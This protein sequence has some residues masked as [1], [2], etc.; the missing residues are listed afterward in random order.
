VKIHHI[1][2]ATMVIET[3]NMV[4]LVDPML[5]DKG[6][7]PS[8][9]EKRFKSQKNPIVPLPKHT[10]KILE[11]VTHCLITHKHEDHLDQAGIDFLK[12]QNIPVFCSINDEKRFRNLGLNIKESFNYWKRAEFL[13]GSIEGIPAIHGYGKVAELM[14]SV[15]GYFITLKGGKSVYLSSDTI[16]TQSVDK[17]LK[18]YL[19]DICVVACGSAQLDEH[20]PILMTMDDIIKFI[21]N[22]PK[23]I[24][25]NHLEALNHCP[26]SRN[27][28]KNRL[29]SENLLEKVWIPEDGETKTI[30]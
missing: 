20:E 9:S 24:I 27:G 16:Y 15:M 2:N 3:K 13:D 18:T 6:S 12:V 11:K 5:G 22:V 26:T 17:V 29:K 14:G 4:L 19:P 1:R 8:F 10:D 7:I 25:A 28:L 21:K 30:T 23:L